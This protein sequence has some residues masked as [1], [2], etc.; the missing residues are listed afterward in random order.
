MVIYG[1]YHSSF[2]A[3]MLEQLEKSDLSDSL[4]EYIKAYFDAMGS[5]LQKPDGDGNE[6]N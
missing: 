5:G 4:K 1:E 6:E 2:R 3:A